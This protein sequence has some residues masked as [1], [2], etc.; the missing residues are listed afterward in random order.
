VWRAYDYIVD[1]NPQAAQRMADALFAAGD[2][3]EH[4]PHRGRL[5]PGTA[6]RELLS[7]SPYIIRYRIAGN[8]VVIQRVR[9]GAQR[10]TNR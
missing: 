2:G 8:D 6:S 9:H 5:V 10:P 3:L 1:F 4:F 7:I